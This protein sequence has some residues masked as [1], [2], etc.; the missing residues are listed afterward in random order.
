MNN[1]THTAHVDPDIRIICDTVAG[2]CAMT[3]TPTPDYT[4][5]YAHGYDTT[6]GVVWIARDT[7]ARAP[8]YRKIYTRTMG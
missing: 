1:A 8:W 3:R 5:R 6:M 2:Q 4:T 7:P